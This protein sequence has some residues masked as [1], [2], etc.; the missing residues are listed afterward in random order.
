M[1]YIIIYVYSS[2]ESDELHEKVG[3]FRVD[4]FDVMHTPIY[5]QIKQ[6]NATHRAIS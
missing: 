6:E 3:F 1:Y 4:C 5:G 2:V